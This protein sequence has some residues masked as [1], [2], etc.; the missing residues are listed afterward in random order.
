M[1]TERD[2]K[3]ELIEAPSPEAL[4]ARAWEASSQN[5]VAR[6]YIA[7]MIDALRFAGVLDVAEYGRLHEHYASL[8]AST[9]TATARSI[10][11]EFPHFP[12][13]EPQIA[14]I[15][16]EFGLSDDTSWHNEA[17]PSFQSRDGAWRLWI[18]HPEPAQRETPEMKRFSLA[19]VDQDGFQLVGDGSAPEYVCE[20]VE[21]LREALRAWKARQ[22]EIQSRTG[23][24]RVVATDTCYPIEYHARGRLLP[25][26]ILEI[27]YPF[28]S[29]SGEAF[30]PS[31]DRGADAIDITHVVF[32][33]GVERAVDASLELRAATRDGTGID[34]RPFSIQADQL[35]VNGRQC[36]DVRVAS[37]LFDADRRLAAAATND[38][39][40][41]YLRQSEAAFGPLDQHRYQ[42]L[43]ESFIETIVKA[44][45]S[46]P[47]VKH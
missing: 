26:D 23:E 33:D 24:V 8:P 41:Q 31:I 9:P 39:F 46:A 22:A 43:L 7:G 16:I 3:T 42:A 27:E 14:E 2:L 32:E 30:E 37:D 34:W 40:E 19:P 15:L 18:D 21:E 45:C 44:C 1:T 20:T 10:K 4:L 29:D 47:S 11:T 25:G 17:C 38:R 6:G 36:I 13:I 12:P 35:M 28:V 5:P